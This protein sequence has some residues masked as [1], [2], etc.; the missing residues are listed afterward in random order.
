MPSCHL[1]IASCAFSRVL[2]HNQL[3]LQLHQLQQC[4]K[5]RKLMGHVLYIWVVSSFVY[6]LKIQIDSL[7]FMTEAA[8]WN[9]KRSV[10]HPFIFSCSSKAVDESLTYLQMCWCWCQVI[11][12]QSYAHG[13]IKT[14]KRLKQTNK[15]TKKNTLK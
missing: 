1:I 4:M 5:A 10:C 9:R 7:I 15:Q 8:S 2:H 12:H 13:Y 3:Q 11:H 14:E 6:L